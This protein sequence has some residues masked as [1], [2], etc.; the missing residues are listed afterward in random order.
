MAGNSYRQKLSPSQ[1]NFQ[2]QVL[3]ELMELKDDNL[4]LNGDNLAKDQMIQERDLK[5][6]Q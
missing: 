6:L 4:R 5:I 2:E 3:Q 1:H